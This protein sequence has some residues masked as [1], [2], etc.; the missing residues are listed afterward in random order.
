MTQHILRTIQANE[1]EAWVN[2]MF[3][4]G[5]YVRPNQAPVPDYPLRFPFPTQ[6]HGTSPGQ[7]LYVVY[8]GKVIGY[9]R[10]DKII[11][12]DG[13]TVGTDDQEVS[14]GD[15][16]ILSGPL[17]K[18][19]FELTCRGFQGPRYTSVDLHLVDQASAQKAVDEAVGR[20]LESE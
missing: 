16:L 4:I 15:A 20:P 9:S 5:P 14:G 7:M 2:L 13:D 3:R 18:M 17:Q 8:R 6:L 11:N 19:P 1:E 10:I 12:Q